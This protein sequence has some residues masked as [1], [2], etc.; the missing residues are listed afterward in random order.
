MIDTVKMVR[1]RRD[2]CVV[3]ETFPKAQLGDRIVLQ[4]TRRE[5]S[6][7]TIG[8]EEVGRAFKD[9]DTGRWTWWYDGMV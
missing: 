2:G 7:A 4:F 8:D 3:I 5:F 9:E 6:Y 1:H